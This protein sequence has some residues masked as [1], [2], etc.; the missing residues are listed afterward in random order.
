MPC[1][2]CGDTKTPSKTHTDGKKYCDKCLLL[3]VNKSLPC[4]LC[5]ETKTNE[6][7]DH[8]DGKKYCTKC[9]FIVTSKYVP[10]ALCKQQTSNKEV[11]TDEKQYC[12]VC[13]E[14]VVNG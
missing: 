3:V 1:C 14:F 13:Y 11:H 4:E 12:R 10:C 2:V 6:I 9:S 8:C 5:T 7:K